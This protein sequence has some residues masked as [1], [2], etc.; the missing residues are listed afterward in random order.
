[1]TLGHLY[2]KK[3][4]RGASEKL[5]TDLGRRSISDSE[6]IRKLAQLYLDQKKYDAAI[7]IL[8]GM[9]K[10][11][12]DSSDI[13]YLQGVAFDR[14]GDKETALIHLKKVRSTSK[15]YQNAAVHMAFI[16]DDQ[17][18]ISEAIRLLE[19]VNR[20]VTPEPEL[21]FYLGT[22]Y[23]EA[24]KL[25]KAVDVLEQGLVKD[26]DSVRILFRLGVVYDKLKRK[27][28]SMEAMRKVIRVDPKNANALNYLGYSYADLGENLDEAEKLIKE[29]LK[30][31]PDDG[32]I[33]D[34]LGWVYFKKGLFQ[35]ALKFLEKAIHLVPDDPII[36]EHLGDAYLK[37]GSKLKA[38]EYYQQSLK[39]KKKDKKD[40]ER[41]I[42]DLKNFGI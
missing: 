26:P 10:G 39:M 14:K 15:F 18:K 28:D 22:F 3:G 16:Y 21:L 12:G 13:H 4:M 7:I 25:Q 20:R 8:N 31:K 23:E 5:F 27:E 32:Y 9:L 1:M 37:T 33:T 40:I 42:Q 35:K 36:L 11:A 6:I 30:Y 17:R 38:L 24:E 29:A 34:S 19:D 41:K 2:H